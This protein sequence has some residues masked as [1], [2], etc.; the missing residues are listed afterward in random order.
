MKKNISEVQLAISITNSCNHNCNYCLRGTSTNDHIDI[1]VVNEILNQSIELGL[2]TVSITGGEPYLHPNF[3]D[4]IRIISRNELS[5]GFVTN[6]SFIEDYK[7]A[8]EIHRPNIISISLNGSIEQIH[9]QTREGWDNACNA[10]QEYSALGIPIHVCYT[11]DQNNE[12]DLED[13]IALVKSL[14]AYTF[15]LSAYIP[16]TGL[17]YV[18]F[19]LEEKEALIERAII[20]GKQHNIKI[21][22]T[23]AFLDITQVSCG[24]MDHPVPHILPTGEIGFCCNL[25]GKGLAIPNNDIKSS[26]KQIRNYSSELTTERDNFLL[27]PTK[28][29]SNCEF[30]YEHFKNNITYFSG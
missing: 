12:Q 25:E 8:I 13:S 7:K 19:T 24:L 27:N 23:A 21:H 1:D 5:Y 15:W 11:M 9:N 14:G 17:D 28:D 26:F 22:C 6:G 18:P 2:H 3:N 10:I 30:C 20:A 4:I 16:T 29:I